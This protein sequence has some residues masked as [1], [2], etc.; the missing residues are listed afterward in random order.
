MR[1]PSTGR[2][3]YRNYTERCSCWTPNSPNTQ[4]MHHAIGVANLSANLRSCRDTC[5]LRSRQQIGEALVAEDGQDVARVSPQ[6]LDD[7]LADSTL[8]NHAHEC[9]PA[10]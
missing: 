8:S 10:L 2:R 3:V 1:W 7:L 5:A 6:P 9:C 4:R